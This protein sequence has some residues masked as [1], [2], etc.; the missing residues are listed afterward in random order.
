MT[1]YT[2]VHMLIV[3]QLTV[4][5][6]ACGEHCLQGKIGQLHDRFIGAIKTVLLADLFDVCIV[7]ITLSGVQ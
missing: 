2:S 7:N 5:P 1:T 4:H 6:H 3:A